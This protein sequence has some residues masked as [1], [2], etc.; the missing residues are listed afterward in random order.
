MSTMKGSFS[1]CE[2]ID[3]ERV[4]K[5]Y[6][7]QAISFGFL[8]NEVKWYK[9]FNN[10]RG[11]RYTPKLLDYTRDTLVLEYVGNHI[12]QGIRLI[13]FKNQLRQIASFL[14]SHHCYHCDII[15]NNLLVL[16]DKLFLIDFGWAV[17]MGEDPFRKWKHV[18]KEIVKCI[19]GA[20]RASDW[21][22]DKYSLTKIYREYSG[23]TVNKIFF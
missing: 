7:D 6:N 23:D 2:V 21:P 18:H 12:T 1:T 13:N 3:D 14:E 17:K 5:K 22:N 16:G 10:I 15:P 11:I 8:D 9:K 4:L 19:G 20:Y